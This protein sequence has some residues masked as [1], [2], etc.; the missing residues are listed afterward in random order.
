MK[1]ISAS[2]EQYDTQENTA[3]TEYRLELLK[4]FCDT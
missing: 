1:E 2:N 4:V 3:T